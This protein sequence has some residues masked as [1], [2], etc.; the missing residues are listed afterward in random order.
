V[1]Q[2]PRGRG[3]AYSY[4]GKNVKKKSENIKTF[5]ENGIDR[6]KTKGK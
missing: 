3:S 4:A 5:E 1:F 6:Q 2:Q